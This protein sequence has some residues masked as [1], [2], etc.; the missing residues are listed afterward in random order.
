[1]A[2]RADCDRRG[3]DPEIGGA[4]AL[5]GELIEAHEGFSRAVTEYLVGAI[6]PPA[7]GAGTL[8]AILSRDRRRYGLLRA[9]S[10]RRGARIDHESLDRMREARRLLAH[11]IDRVEARGVRTREGDPP[12]ISRSELRRHIKSA[13]QATRDLGGRDP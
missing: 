8:R 10:K 11:S 4:Y 2:A 12:Y 5:V 6:G 9:Y 13:R 7:G 1:M 3:R